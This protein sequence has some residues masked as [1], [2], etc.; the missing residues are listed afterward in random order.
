MPAFE[1]VQYP[2]SEGSFSGLVVSPSQRGER[3]GVLVFH[4]GAGLGEHERD[5]ARMLA[6]LGYIAFVPD[7][8]GERFQDRAHGMAVITKLTSEAE[9]LRDRVKAALAWLKARTHVAPKR[10]AAIGF[11]FGGLAAL[12]LARSGADVGAVV[13]FHGG[14]KTRAPAQAGQVAARVLVC[15]GGADPFVS[16]EDRLAFEDEMVQAKADWQVI[17]HGGALHGFTERNL[18]PGKHPG[19]GYHRGADRMSWRAMRELFEETLGTPR[20]AKRAFFRRG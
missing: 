1:S 19:C 10:V 20:P 7:L 17:V 16:R 18:D 5:R 6:E 11:C 2:V 9:L 13:S 15:A 8:F 3:P 4:G 14:L 12:E